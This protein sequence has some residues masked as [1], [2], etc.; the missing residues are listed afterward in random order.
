MSFFFLLLLLLFFLLFLRVL[1]FFLFFSLRGRLRDLTHNH[2][3]ISLFDSKLLN[4]ILIVDIFAF[5]HKF[6][7]ISL[8][9]LCLLNFVFQC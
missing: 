3:E 4:T 2:N 9:I 8:Y 6:Q 5:E 7:G 1:R